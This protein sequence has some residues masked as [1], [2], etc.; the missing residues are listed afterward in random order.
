MDKLSVNSVITRN[1]EI[2]T[3]EIDGETVMMSIEM[4]KYYSLGKM[5]S[6]IWDL[7]ETPLTLEALINKLLDTYDVSREQ[8]QAEVTAFLGDTLENGLVTLTAGTESE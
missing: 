3:A 4:G 1:A 7:L 6:V 2:V 8:C 5:G